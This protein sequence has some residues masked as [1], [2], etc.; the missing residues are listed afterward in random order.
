MHTIFGDALPVSAEQLKAIMELESKKEG[1]KIGSLLYELGK[2]E[3]TANPE[4]DVREIREERNEV[5]G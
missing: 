4:K 2:K 1:I 5:S 3:K